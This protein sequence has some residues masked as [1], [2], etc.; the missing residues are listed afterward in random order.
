MAEPGALSVYLNMNEY[1]PIRGGADKSLARPGRINAT[2]T[3]LWIYSTY[4][5]RS[6]IHFLARCS[7]FCKSLK[8][9]FRRL[10]VQPGLRGSNDLR[11]ERKMATF[12]LFFSVQG[13]GGS[14]MGPDPANSVGNQGTGN[15]GKPVS[16]GL[17]VPGEP[18]HCR[19][20]I[21]PPW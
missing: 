13:T 14:P 6:P 21:R 8:K 18:G 11:V 3:K 1:V 12:Q 16:S 20:R 10:S 7:N 15:P 5:P 17:Q 2:A 19:A 4:S 9:K